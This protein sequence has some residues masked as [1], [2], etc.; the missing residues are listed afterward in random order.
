MSKTNTSLISARHKAILILLAGVIL[1]FVIFTGVRLY[2]I[3]KQKD[4]HY[5]ANFQVW[6]NGVQEKFESPLYYQEISTCSKNGHSNPLHRAHMHDQKYDVVHIHDSAVT[7]SHFFENINSSVQP[8]YLRIGNNIYTNNTENKLG[9]I[10]NGKSV[11]SLN[12]VEIK[13]EDSLLVS[14]GNEDS[15]ALQARYGNMTNK[16]RSYN[17]LKD[18]ASCSGDEE[19]N[20]L[21]RLN[22]IVN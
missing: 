12:N 21:D 17:I 7:W 2:N 8:S 14:Y 13:S 4:A 15:Q 19:L 3:S 10:L 18:P 6:V 9:I 16:A 5:H 20:F 11:N 22:S 1:G